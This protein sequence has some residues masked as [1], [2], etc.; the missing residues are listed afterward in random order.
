LQGLLH[1]VELERLNDR[2]DLFH[3]V[4]S[5]AFSATF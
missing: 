4:A 3:V 1:F 5:H 2:F